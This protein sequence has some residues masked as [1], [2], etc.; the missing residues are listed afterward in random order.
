MDNLKDFEHLIDPFDPFRDPYLSKQ[1]DQVIRNIAPM[2]SC[3]SQKVISANSR[4][5]FNEIDDAFLF[6]ALTCIDQGFHSPED[7]SIIQNS[8]QI[9]K[10]LPKSLSI[11]PKQKQERAQPSTL[12][13]L[14]FRLSQGTDLQTIRDNWLP[15]KSMSEIKH[16][17]KNMTC[18]RAVDNLLKRWKFTHYTPLR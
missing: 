7:S 15:K 14:N 13:V 8:G 5:K 6:G 17:F 1:N 10:H 2:S 16:R 12:K 18:I 11:T 3:I 4:R 9:E